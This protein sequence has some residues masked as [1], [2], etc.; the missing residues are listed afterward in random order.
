MKQLNWRD[1]KGSAMLLVVFIIIVFAMLG[2]A[3]MGA[4]I[5]GAQRSETRENDVQSLHL[6]EMALNEAAASVALLFKDKEDIDLNTLEKQLNAIQLTS[7][8]SQVGG[9]GEVIKFNPEEI[10]GEN[11]GGDS[12]KRFT[13]TVQAKAMVNGV[14]RILE[15]EIKLD[16]YPDFLKYGL[17]SE[18]NVIL[19]GAPYLNGDLYSGIKLYV[20]NQAN[21][22]YNKSPSDKSYDLA[23][24]VFPT[25]KGDLFIQDKNSIEA[26]DRLNNVKTIVSLEDA[27]K[28]AQTTGLTINHIQYRDLKKFVSVNIDETFLDKIAE[29]V[30]DTKINRKYNYPSFNQ[31]EEN[32]LSIGAVKSFIA[33]SLLTHDNISY[34]SLSTEKPI[35]PGPNA[36]DETRANYIDDLTNYYEPFAGKMPAGTAIFN[37]DLTVDGIEFQNILFSEKDKT[38]RTPKE[39]PWV[40]HK[41]NWLIVNGDLNIKNINKL[42]ELEVK[43]NILV[44]GNVF[45]QGKVKMDATI[46]ALG[47]STIQDAEIS[48]LD[49]RELLL[50]SK[51]K[52]LINRFESFKAPAFLHAFLY[53]DSDAELYGVGSAFWI[54]GGF[55]A[56]GDLVINAVLGDTTPIDDSYLEFDRINKLEDV[57]ENRLKS[58]FVVEYNKG[59]YEDQNVGL[60]RVRQIN[61]SMGKKKLVPL[62][63]E[64]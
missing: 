8:Q 37:G 63:Q 41:S 44:T 62:D 17:G 19:N 60:P 12:T 27:S 46:I 51:G 48:G 21:Y 26:T 53:T 54:K 36:N 47:E 9:T 2:I 31:G 5:G 42:K 45:I 3:L 14:V 7:V 28:L 4:T 52:I 61:V 33:T 58:R 10:S 50:I 16:S 13:I 22:R 39:E 23:D 24:T 32:E 56:K 34:I 15:Q 1:E 29:A 6:A 64:Q 55:F 20:K 40:D 43:A 35:D 49:N 57:P 18:N 30:G 38:D 59:I 25:I 11:V